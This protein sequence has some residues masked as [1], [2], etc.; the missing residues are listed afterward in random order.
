MDI[1]W[2]TLAA[3]IVSTRLASAEI[4][5]PC[6]DPIF[7]LRCKGEIGFKLKRSSW[8]RDSTTFRQPEIKP[9][10]SH[11]FCRSSKE[12]PG[13]LKWPDDQGLILEFDD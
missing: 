6:L 7:C 11:A 8:A 9:P 2:R 1:L 13:Q 3:S 4:N 10:G 5:S 12:S